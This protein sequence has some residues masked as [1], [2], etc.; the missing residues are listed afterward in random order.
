MLSSPPL[1]GDFMKNNYV[2]QV[3]SGREV[4]LALSRIGAQIIEDHPELDET[5]LIGIRTRGVPLAETLRKKIEKLSGKQLL[6]GILDITFYRDDL[7]M[8][9][10]QPV[11]EGSHLNFDVAGKDVILV[12]DVLFTGRTTRA[13]LDNVID[14]GRPRKVKLVVLVDR[15]HRELP[16]QADYVGKYVETAVNEVVEVRVNAVDNEDGV[17]LTT[18]ELLQRSDG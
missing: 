12:D 4:D 16:I 6:L 2:R 7:S 15:G 9:D 1:S 17:Y 10:T 18:R 14:Y 3:M 13:A 8:V 5:V 11:V